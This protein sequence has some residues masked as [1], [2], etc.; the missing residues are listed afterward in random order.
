MKCHP[1]SV[2]FHIRA[3]W[4]D[5]QCGTEEARS[6]VSGI[7]PYQHPEIVE[8]LKQKTPEMKLLEF[9]DGEIFRNPSTPLNHARLEPWEGSATSLETR[10][11]NPPSKIIHEARKLL[12]W[13]NS[14]G[15]Y[16]GRLEDSENEHI[17]GRVTSRKHHGQT[18]WT[19]QPPRCPEPLHENDGHPEPDQELPPP[20]ANLVN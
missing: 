1:R 18:I 20:P 15:A 3:Q 19:I 12:A 14:R 7:T 6:V 5:W 9:I 10:L 17:T 8:K 2:P 4:F 11:V 16:L 13:Q